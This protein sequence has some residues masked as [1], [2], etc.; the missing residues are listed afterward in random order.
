MQR[1]SILEAL[2]AVFNATSVFPTT[3]P[4]PNSNA[5]LPILHGPAATNTTQSDMALQAQQNCNQTCA[6]GSLTCLV[7][8]PND[9]IYCWNTYSGCIG[10][11]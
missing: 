3:Q 4:A 8:L 7:A 5:I 11:C 2:F 10:R 9:P 1:Q 6:L